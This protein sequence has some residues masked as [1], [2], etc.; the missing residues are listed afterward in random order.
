[1]SSVIATSTG[2]RALVNRRGIRE[3]KTFDVKSEAQL[4]ASNREHEI[5]TGTS[6]KQIAKEHTLHK[7]LIRFRDEDAQR[8]RGSR[9]EETRINRFMKELADIPLA[10]LDKMYIT[11]WRNARLE[12]VKGSS[13]RR[14]MNLLRTILETARRDWGWLLVNPMDDVKKPSTPPSRKR[15]ITQEEI[16]AVV[17]ALGYVE[18]GPIKSVGQTIAVAFLIALETGMRAG[19]LL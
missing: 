12:E 6:P 13:V 18:D 16:D 2:W 1:M 8:R 17:G 10:K 19:E 7:V 11:E 5:L 3:S 15:L 14:D 4:W 9:W